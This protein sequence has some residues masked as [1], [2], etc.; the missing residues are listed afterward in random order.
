MR[1]RGGVLL[2]T[3]LLVSVLVAPAL[4]SNSFLDLGRAALDQQLRAPAPPAAGG[5]VSSLPS[6]DIAA[7]LREALSNGVNSVTSRLGAPGG[8]NTDPSVHIPLP[9]SLRAVRSGLA[10]VGASGAADELE[11]KLNRAA[12]AAMPQAREIFLGALKKMTL[13]DARGILAGPSDAATQ[14]FRRTM[15]PDLSSAMRPVVDRTVG[16]AGAVQAYESLTSGMKGLPVVADGR[17]LLTDHVLK[18]GLDGLF[19]SLGH[20]EASIRANPAART[21]ELLRKVFTN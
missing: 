13:E 9:D 6:S 21:S 5:T 10:L 14:Y 7:G 17:T 15:T 16:E 1:D 18:Y 11:G 4:A 3:G 20:E 12:E 19:S 8:F 2:T